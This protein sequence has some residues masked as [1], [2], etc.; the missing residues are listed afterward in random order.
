MFLQSVRV[1][2]GKEPFGRRPFRLRVRVR[3]LDHRDPLSESECFFV[4]QKAREDFFQK[5]TRSPSSIP[6]EK[7]G[8]THFIEQ[9]QYVTPEEAVKV[10][11]DIN[12]LMNLSVS[13]NQRL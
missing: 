5:M 2:C 7:K 1:L 10:V 9:G 6:K 3:L 12:R 13:M 8:A 11:K 4:F